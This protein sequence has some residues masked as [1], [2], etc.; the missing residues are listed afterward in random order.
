MCRCSVSIPRT[1]R[2]ARRSRSAVQARWSGE[3]RTPLRSLR[4]ED[5]RAAWL[6]RP[7]DPVV[8]STLRPE[9]REFAVQQAL[10]EVSPLFLKSRCGL[11]GWV[12]IAM[13]PLRDL[14]EARREQV[15]AVAARHHAS[16]VRLFGSVARGVRTGT[17]TFSMSLSTCE[18]DRRPAGA[19]HP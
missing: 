9:S 10:A 3:I 6:R 7:G 18:P 15:K 14:V 5:V 16:R 13:S 19:G 1:S 4:L 8:N 2:P 11:R 17:G 12:V